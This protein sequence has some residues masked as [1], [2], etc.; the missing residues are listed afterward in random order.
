M[1]NTPLDI[2]HDCNCVICFVGFHTVMRNRFGAKIII[3]CD[4]SGDWNMT[5]TQ[6]YGDSLSG[7]SVWASRWNPF[8]KEQN[9]SII[10]IFRAS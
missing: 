10:V 9:V 6:S 7:L 2:I 3:A 4:V 5:A 1:I 8:S